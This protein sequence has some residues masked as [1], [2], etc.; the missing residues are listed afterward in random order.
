M[1]QEVQDHKERGQWEL[2][3]KANVAEGTVILP[4][5][6]SMKCKLRITTNEIYKWKA[7]L[8]VHGGKQIKNVHYWETRHVDIET[9]LYMDIPKGFHLHGQQSM[10]CLKLKKNLYGQ[11]QAGRVWNHFLHSGLTNLRFQQSTVEECV[12]YCGSSILLCYV[13]DTLIDPSNKMIDKIIKQL[14]DHKFNVQFDVQDEGQIKD[15]PGVRIQH[16]KDGTI[17]MSQPHLIEQ[18]LQDLNLVSL[19]GM[20]D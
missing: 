11:R 20:T 18:V 16:H 17:E 8:N 7:R 1:K 15:Y 13:N 3:P 2:I 10:H 6:W 4:S 12:Y 14:Q 5:V 19:N 9:N